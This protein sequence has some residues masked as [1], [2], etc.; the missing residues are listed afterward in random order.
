MKTIKGFLPIRS[1]A[2]FASDQCSSGIHDTRTRRM[3]SS[4]YS[5]KGGRVDADQILQPEVAFYDSHSSGIT[6]VNSV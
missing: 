5:P 4:F 3:D 6:N 1:I 2:A